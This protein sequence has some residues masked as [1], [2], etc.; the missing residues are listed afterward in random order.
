MTI[1]RACD[2]SAAPASGQK[3][4][5]ASRTRRSLPSSKP[6]SLPSDVQPAEPFRDTRL[7]CVGKFE[8]V[9]CIAVI[10]RQEKRVA[11]QPRALPEYCYLSPEP[12]VRSSLSSWSQK[13]SH[14]SLALGWLWGRIRV[15]LGWL[16][17]AYQLAIN[18]LCG[19]FDV[20]LMWL[21][22]FQHFRFQYFSFCHNGASG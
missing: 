16:W 14:N 22:R 19:G 8:V 18:T 4:A 1:E 9:A 15:A 10:D 6:G 13:S 17:G 7:A 2:R 12:L 21:F 3:F 11:P 5:A 20:A